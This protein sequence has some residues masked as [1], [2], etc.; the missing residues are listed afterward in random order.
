M[1]AR[2][3]H[4][5]LPSTLDPW[6]LARAGSRLSGVVPLAGMTR[7]A[8][9]VHA[10]GE[11]A[12]VELC[13]G[14]DE[15]KRFRIDGFIDARVELI[16]QRCLQPYECRLAARPKLVVL[17]E[18]ERAATLP[19]ELDPLIVDQVMAPVALVEDELILALPLI[20]RHE[21]TCSLPEMPQGKASPEADRPGD[22]RRPFAEL[23]QL[24]RRND[25]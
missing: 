8:E 18:E 22:T 7:L 19:A 12:E 4:D 21:Q 2:F 16:C 14:V 1:I 9:M 23:G 17:V 5:P 20:P 13:F 6:L 25:D 3:M 11:S 10:L 15:Q 24:L